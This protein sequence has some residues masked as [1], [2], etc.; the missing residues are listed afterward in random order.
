MPD[1]WFPIKGNASSKPSYHLPDT[2][3]YNR[4][5]AEVWFATEEAA[6]SCWFHP[7]GFA[8]EEES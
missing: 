1:G 4:T 3:F 6:E 8:A 5:V 2:S 7:P